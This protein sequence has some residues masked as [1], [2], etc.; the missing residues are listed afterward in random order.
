MGEVLQQNGIGLYVP[1]SQSASGISRLNSGDVRNARKIARK[2]VRLLADAVRQGYHIVATEPSALLCLK[3]EYP[4]LLDDED[5]HLVAE[6]SSEAC[7]YL[8]DLHQ[9]KQLNLDF[10]RVDCR[11]AYHQPC[12]LRVLDPECCATKLLSLIPGIEVENID[13]GCSGMAGTWGLQRKNYR[14]SL[15]IGWPVISKM[16]SAR[17]SIATTE[18]S[19]CKMQI[20]HGSDRTTLH[21][22][23]LVAHAYGRMPKIQSQL[24]G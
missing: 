3:H 9:S 8:W 23:K 2:N 11:I 13:A 6:H 14:S 24:S 18:C 7:A 22:L 10:S 16:R 19:A 1:P 12:H 15:R 21:P 20:E 17:V 5:A 4:N